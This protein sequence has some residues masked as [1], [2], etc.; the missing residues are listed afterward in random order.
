MKNIELNK[1]DIQ[2][3]INGKQIG[4][5]SYGVVYEY[6]E[7]SVVKLYF[8]IPYHMDS[9]DNIVLSKKNMER[10]LK[11]KNAVVLEKKI[12]MLNNTSSK[13]LITGVLIYKNYPIG[14]KMKYYKNY[15]TLD[16]LIRR[17][18]IDNAAIKKI[19][20]SIGDSIKSLKNQGIYTTDL[21]ARNIL[22]NPETLEIKLIDLDDDLTIYAN[23][24][25]NSNY[26]DVKHEVS[27]RFNEIINFMYLSNKIGN[28]NR[29][30]LFQFTRKRNRKL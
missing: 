11:Q 3:I 9:L 13:E 25:S 20:R 8:G 6:D 5:G 7:D 14:I 24:V 1:N 16:E 23:S 18:S 4:D 26:R 21:N 29:L 27:S 12:E 15:I 28:E 17:Y 10:S 30:N 22:I 2:Y 19:I